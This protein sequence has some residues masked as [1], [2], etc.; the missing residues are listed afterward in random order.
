MAS[1]NYFLIKPFTGSYNLYQNIMDNIMW[2]F[3][4]TGNSP[5]QRRQSGGPRPSR[6]DVAERINP[7][8]PLDIQQ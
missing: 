7:D 5:T 6:V 3:S 1:M 4:L 8:I 2:L